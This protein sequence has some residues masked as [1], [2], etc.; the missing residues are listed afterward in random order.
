MKR[1]ADN[2]CAP[3]SKKVAKECNVCYEPKKGHNCRMCNK[4]IC[5][6]CL[7]QWKATCNKQKKKPDC[8]FC[9]TIW[10]KPNFYIEAPHDKPPLGTRISIYCGKSYE[11]AP[12]TKEGNVQGFVVLD[13]TLIATQISNEELTLSNLQRLEKYAAE[14]KWLFKD[15]E[16]NS[17]VMSTD[18]SEEHFKNKFQQ[19]QVHIENIVSMNGEQFYGSVELEELIMAGLLFGKNPF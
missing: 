6:S 3:P 15:L 4:H 17:A 19:Q 5:R 16:C 7:K 8:P 13:P 9:R 10:D 14:I 2:L 11:L 1:S 18:I 12:I